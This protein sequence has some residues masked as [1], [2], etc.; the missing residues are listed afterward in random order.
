M[1]NI[2]K[3]WIKTKTDVEEAHHIWQKAEWLAVDTEFIRETTFFPRV[4]LIQIA[5]EKQVWLVDP[6]SL[7]REDLN[8]FLEV[9][10]NPKILKV[11]HAAFADQECLYWE[12]ETLAV[13]ILDT[14]VAAALVGRGD[15]IGL[16]RLVR[17]LLGIELS[18][19]HARAKWMERPL[20]AQL[21]KY[22]EEDVS[23]LVQTG[24]KLQSELEALGRWDWAL[25]ESEVA[26]SDI[27]VPAESIADRLSKSTLLEPKDMGVLLELVR[28]R[29]GRAKQGDLPRN[30]VADNETL[31]AISK[32]KPETLDRLSAFRGLKRREVEKNGEEILAAIARGKKIA[33][34]AAKKGFVFRS[35]ESSIISFVQTYVGLLSEELQIAPRFLLT[36]SGIPKLIL[37]ADKTV[38]E[39]VEDGCL[40]ERAGKMIGEELKALLSG[41]RGL[42]IHGG[43]LKATKV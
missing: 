27:N 8:P 36:G 17:D 25:S 26:L 40:S 33:P 39:W 42:V 32:V 1:T 29:E 31:I 20:P 11:M 13:P 37:S 4:A 21:E 43:K 5:T 2:N 19:G 41:K 23:Y 28:W 15:N 22:A 34:L 10:T 6:L 14:S 35:V 30:W 18:K 16:G 3:R 12:Y 9:L 7:S 24:R 38:A